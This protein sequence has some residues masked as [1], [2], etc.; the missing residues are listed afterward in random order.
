MQTPDFDTRPLGQEFDKRCCDDFEQSKQPSMIK[1]IL[2]TG[3]TFAA[4][5][6]SIGTAFRI[7]HVTQDVNFNLLKK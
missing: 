6:L 4:I 1:V 3:L 7:A 2:V 5:I